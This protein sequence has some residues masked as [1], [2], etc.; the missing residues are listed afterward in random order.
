MLQ[1]RKRLKDLEE[2]LVQVAEKK[3]HLSEQLTAAEVG[4]EDTAERAAH[5]SELKQGHALKTKLNKELQE[6]R[7]CDP[8]HMAELS[9]SHVL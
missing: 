7:S 1:S 5:L 9:M 4:K 8:Q 3:Q 6:Y 2:R